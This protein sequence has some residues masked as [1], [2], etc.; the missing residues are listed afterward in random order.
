MISPKVRYALSRRSLLVASCI[1]AIAALVCAQP[2][3]QE[4]SP[5]KTARGR[6]GMVAA[7]TPYAT[8]AGVEILE[9]G[10]N[11]VD[12]AAAAACFALMVTDPAMTS[13]GGRVQMLITLRD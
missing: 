6:H 13:L 8:A 10:G 5:A 9:A 12:A 11:A 1:L 3:P 4:P 7:G 2:V